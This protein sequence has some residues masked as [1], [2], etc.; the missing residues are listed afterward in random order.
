VIVAF[1]V[2]SLYTWGHWGDLRVDTGREVMYR[3]AALAHGKPL[4]TDIWYQ[5]PPLAIQAVGL[6]VRVFGIGLNTLYYLGLAMTLSCALLLLAVSRRLLPPVAAL[7]VALSFVLQAFGPDEFNYI[8]PYTS[9]ALFGVLFSFAF[10]YFLLRHVRNEPGRNLLFAAV[11]AGGAALSKQEFGGICF[12]VLALVAGAEF[13]T[14]RSWRKL[15]LV[16]LDC[17]PGTLLVVAVY[18]WLLW[19]F[20]PNFI[21]LENFQVAPS[22]YFMKLYGA[23]WVADHGLRF[24]PGEILATMGVT[25]CS[26]AIWAILAWS[27]RSKFIDRWFLHILCAVVVVLGAGFVAHVG[28]AR[29]IV[30]QRFRVEF[31]MFPIGM[32]WTSCGLVIWSGV[33][34]IRSRFDA[35]YLPFLTVGLFALAIGLR[36]MVQ[37][38]PRNYSIFYSPILFLVFIMTVQA[39]AE[40]VLW[41]ATAEARR[42]SINGLM[43]V[44]ALAL[45]VLL[46][47]APHYYPAKLVTR[48][49]TIYTRPAEA[50]L[51]PQV[52]GFVEKQKAEGKRVLMLP[53]EA[54]LYFFCGMDPPTRWVDLMPGMLLPER[55]DEYISQ[56]QAA[57]IDYVLLSNRNT[58]EYGVPYFGLDFHQKV[59]RWIQEN[60]E[61]VGELGRFARTRQSPYAMLIFKRRAERNVPAIR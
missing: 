18:G 22:A 21:L 60:Y 39:V 41:T 3:S 47:P 14:H 37:V 46:M 11:S 33:A 26:L 10:L 57:G 43:V 1:A 44:E 20:S 61:A 31:A 45:T 55:E 52:I 8:L 15:G 53:E 38:E 49:G 42:R 48:F 54:A 27:R 58:E 23:K 2:L 59:Y 19:R 17:L 5:Y 35:R 50:E 40:R 9:A 32:Y 28:W 36:I 25:V 16:I 56:L 51:F 13:L 34:F 24:R 12:L 7:V 6:V 30:A 29:Y 4:Y